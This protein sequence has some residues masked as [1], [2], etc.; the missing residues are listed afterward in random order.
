MSINWNVVA[1]VAAV[2][3]YGYLAWMICRRQIAAGLRRIKELPRGLQALFAVIAVVATVEAQKSGTNGVNNAGGGNTNMMMSAGL[4]VPLERIRFPDKLSLRDDCGLA[5]D[6]PLRSNGAYTLTTND[7][8]NGYCVVSQ[9]YAPDAQLPSNAVV[10]G[11]WNI[12][13]AASAFGANKVDF[14]GFPFPFGSSGTESSSSWVSPNGSIRSDPTDPSTEMNTG[15]GEVVAVPGESLLARSEEAN[16]SQTLWWWH[17]YRMPDTNTPL[18]AALTLYPNGSFDVYVTNYWEECESVHPSAWLSI[19]GPSV[20]MRNG[21]TNTVSVSFSSPYA[22]EATPT[23]EC[24]SGSGHVVIETVDDS[25]LH[26]R[27]LSVSGLDEVKFTA[28]VTVCGET[29]TATHSMTVAAVKQLNM[30]CQY[31]GTSANPPP[32][33]GEQEYP[34]AI[35]NSLNPDK[36]LVVPFCNVATQTESGFSVADFTV[37]MSLE[38]EPAGVSPYELGGEWELIEATPEPSGS[39]VVY[40]PIDAE[41]TNP[42]KGGVYRF[43]A[44]VGGSP[45]TEANVVLPLCGASVENI[46]EADMQLVYSVM[47]NVCNKYEEEERVKPTFGRRWFVW[48]GNGDYAGRV[49]NASFRTIWLYNQVDDI[50]GLGAVATWYGYPTRMA[51]L[52]NLVVGYC[53]EMIGV[54]RFRQWISQGIGTWNDSTATMSWDCG[55][56]LASGGNITTKCSACAYEMWEEADDKVKRLWPNTHNADNHS[57]DDSEFDFNHYFWSPGLIQN[58]QTLLEE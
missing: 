30:E 55:V 29:Y 2:A 26:V 37:Y 22:N 4:S 6:V 18:N 23:I 5:R 32:F 45:W 42:K 16:G 9:T 41:F 44:R 46:F 24:S 57:V 25:T 19:S 47:T 36:H 52:S 34:F 49:D 1:V 17:F 11:N 28:S 48:N 7:V 20:I 10:V 33:L 50:S 27:G 35:T 21:T 12:H 56:D 54:S 3:L 8:L 39:L 53:T 14:P 58:S 13:G 40:S 43:R 51:K 31:A 38:L 15:I